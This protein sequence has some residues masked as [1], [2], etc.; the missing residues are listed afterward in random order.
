MVF[1]PLTI[2]IPLLLGK[3]P[4]FWYRGTTV[5][6][7]FLYAPWYYHSFLV[8]I[9]EKVLWWHHGAVT[10]S[11]GNTL[12]SFTITSKTGLLHFQNTMAITSFMSKLYFFKMW[13]LCYDI[14]KSTLLWYHVNTMVFLP[15]TLPYHGTITV[16]RK[17]VKAWFYGYL[18]W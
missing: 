3:I 9:L 11:D 1:P 17:M 7:W 2:T 16:L 15:V 4:C 14:N 5:T 13:Y 6:P 8:R 18:Q 10:V 12:E